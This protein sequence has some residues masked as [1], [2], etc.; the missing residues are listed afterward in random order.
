MPI[1]NLVI[2]FFVLAAIFLFWLGRHQH[3]G[4]LQRE[5]TV[6]VGM[7]EAEV[8]TSLGPPR[9]ISRE[10]DP[11]DPGFFIQ[12]RRES[13]HYGN[14][15]VVLFER[16]VVQEV[17]KPAPLP[18]VDAEPV[19]AKPSSPPLAAPTIEAASTQTEGDSTELPTSVLTE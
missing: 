17:S 12:N 6:E 4:V 13:Y 14:R 1:V 16:G 11:L 2:L 9:E 15:L 3:R 19:E 18:V 10:G 8:L 5:Q 7:T